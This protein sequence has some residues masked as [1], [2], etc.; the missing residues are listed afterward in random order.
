MHI[1]PNHTAMTAAE[2]GLSPDIITHREL[3]P[4]TAKMRPDNYR[5][6][7]DAWLENAPAE[8]EVIAKA[9]DTSNISKFL[10]KGGAA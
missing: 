6:K 8:A 3:R 4:M 9:K 5:D 10:R 2:M 1:I 7:L